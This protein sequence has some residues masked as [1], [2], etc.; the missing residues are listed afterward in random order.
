MQCGQCGASAAATAQTSGS[1]LMELELWRRW[2]SWSAA[3]SSIQACIQT[4]MQ[5]C[6][7]SSLSQQQQ[8]QQPGPA[9]SL[10]PPAA[11]AGL[12][13][14]LPAVAWGRRCRQQ[15]A[16]SAAGAAAVSSS[17]GCAAA[18]GRCAT[19]ARTASGGTG[20]S[21]TSSVLLGGRGRAGARSWPRSSCQPPVR[22]LAALRAAVCAH[23][24]RRRH[25]CQ[26]GQIHRRTATQ[27][28]A[29]AQPAASRCSSGHAEARWA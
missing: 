8:Q 9:L 21:T 18:A 14:S 3:G 22:E 23:H 24:Q 12:H 15:P 10:P 20:L 25:H 11:A 6:Q 16:P 7:S 2:C 29:T 19:A 13:S 1:G 27:A 4:S 5:L 28:P 17:C 26:A